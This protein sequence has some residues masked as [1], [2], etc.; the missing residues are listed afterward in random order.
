MP[1]C[2]TCVSCP[3]PCPDPSADA[4]G[5]SPWDLGLSV[6]EP[7]HEHAAAPRPPSTTAD[8]RTPPPPPPDCPLHLCSHIYPPGPVISIPLHGLLSLPHSA[9]PL[10]ARTPTFAFSPSPPTFAFFTPAAF[11]SPRSILVS[12]S[13]SFQLLCTISPHP[14]ALH[15][16]RQHHYT[17]A[18]FLLLPNPSNVHILNILYAGHHVAGPFAPL[19][20]LIAAD[21]NYDLPMLDAHRHL[22]R[23]V[24]LPQVLHWPK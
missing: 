1:L 21:C 17:R 10:P 2:K 6:A 13:F 20:P 22:L 5:H 14:P 12:R 7:P 4:P 9:R 8:G 23:R 19:W 18:I 3:R 24:Y 15:H 11:S 16:F